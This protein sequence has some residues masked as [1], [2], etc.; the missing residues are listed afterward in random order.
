MN[1]KIVNVKNVKMEFKKLLKYGTSIHWGFN[2]SLPH[3]D[4]KEALW[5]K[6]RQYN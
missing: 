1:F 5:K 3:R 4:I 2:H 6:P